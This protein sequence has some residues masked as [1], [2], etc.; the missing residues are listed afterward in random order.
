MKYTSAQAN[1]ILVGLNVDRDALLSKEQLGLE[2]TAATCENLDD[3]RPPY[4][5]AAVQAELAEI[6]AKI[7]KVKHA[8][9]TFN[10][11]HE[12]PEFNM[13][14]DMAL[15]YIPQL[16]QRKNKLAGMRNRLAKMRCQN[17]DGSNL[18]NYTYANYDIEKADADYKAAAA[19]LAKLQNALDLENSTA[20]FEIDI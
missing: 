8:I 6:E 5:Y 16:T 13:T 1:K 19:E 17:Y 3:A 11:S 15:V 20:E 14:I 12:I 10:V 7:R 4:D 18:I 2:F 9:N